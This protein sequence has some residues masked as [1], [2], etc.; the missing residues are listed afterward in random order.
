MALGDSFSSG[1]GAPPYGYLLNPPEEE[2]GCHR[3]P[4]SW[5]ALTAAALGS[6]PFRFGACSGAKIEAFWQSWTYKRYIGNTKLGVLIESEW[7]E[8]PQ[9]NFVASFQSAEN[10]APDPNVKLVTFSIGGNNTGFGEILEKCVSQN[11]VS[12]KTKAEW[13]DL[14][15]SCNTEGALKVKGGIGWLEGVNPHALMGTLAEIHKIAPNAWIRVLLY[16]QI[17]SDITK[18]GSTGEQV[19][20]LGKSLSILVSSKE[21]KDFIKWETELNDAI[22]KV[23]KKF[24]K[25]LNKAESGSVKV[26]DDENALENGN[27]CTANRPDM[28]PIT[29][30]SGVRG[31]VEPQ[32]AH[33]TAAG[34]KLMSE[35]VLLTLEE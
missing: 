29:T 7:T 13:A 33:P 17:I 3:S 9:F 22:E 35:R 6:A 24:G 10:W 16:P 20:N 1:E 2:N 18:P 12:E 31:I 21:I 32:S 23:V 14:N 28:N 11:Q 26:V 15:K 34:Y 27:L 19:C 25:P 5:P 4:E 8:S 30:F